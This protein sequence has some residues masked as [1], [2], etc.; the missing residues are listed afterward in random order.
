MK[1]GK[2]YLS[3]VEIAQIGTKVKDGYIRITLQR[4]PRFSPDDPLE[5]C[6]HVLRKIKV[7]VWLPIFHSVHSYW[8]DMAYPPGKVNPNRDDWEDAFTD[9][10][11]RLKT[12]FIIQ[13][14]SV[15]LPVDVRISF[16]KVLNTISEWEDS[17]D[18]REIL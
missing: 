9:D 8:R 7:F 15:N 6:I 17:D 2:T 1:H 11:H 4:K 12:A 5:Y 14:D 18:E 10:I 13:A 3:L 16:L